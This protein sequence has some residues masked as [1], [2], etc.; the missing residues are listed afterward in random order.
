M[1]TSPAVP[2]ASA[3]TVPNSTATGSR[4]TP[5][6]HAVLALSGCGRVST[7]QLGKWAFSASAIDTWELPGFVPIVVQ[8]GIADNGRD[9]FVAGTRPADGSHCVLLHVDLTA[10]TR[11]A[12]LLSETRLGGQVIK[13]MLSLQC[14]RTIVAGLGHLQDGSVTSVPMQRAAAATN[15][16]SWLSRSLPIAGRPG[17]SGRPGSASTIGSW[18]AGNGCGV[19]SIGSG[20]RNILAAVEMNSAAVVSSIATAPNH[21]GT[22]RIWN[23]SALQAL[24]AASLEIR[25]KCAMSSATGAAHRAVEWTDLP[26][27]ADAITHLAA[28]HFDDIVIS[29][30]ADGGV[31]LISLCA[32]EGTIKAPARSGVGSS[33]LRLVHKS[34]ITA[35][36]LTHAQLQQSLDDALGVAAAAEREDNATSASARSMLAIRLERD[37]EGDRDRCRLLCAEAVEMRE[38]FAAHALRRHESAIAELADAEAVTKSRLA[39]AKERRENVSDEL[40][41]IRQFVATSTAA[42]AAATAANCLECQSKCK[43]AVAIEKEHCAALEVKQTSLSTLFASMIV[44]REAAADDALAAHSHAH[45]VALAVETASTLLLRGENGLMKRRFAAAMKELTDQRNELTSLRRAETELADGIVGLQR[46]II[47]HQ[48]EVHERDQVVAD[49]DSRIFELRRKNQ[50][51]INAGSE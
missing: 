27:H 32:P 50:V 47:A 19:R 18:G 12:A 17:S 13:S 8:C 7:G 1:M 30:S 20:R 2:T 45:D 33:E 34:A 11:D 22:L 9:A 28:T 39:V 4:N 24:T 15:G 14:G 23:E 51:H 43:I 38:R 29:G 31:A 6:T 40:E 3:H 5:H 46:D 48:K 42:A 26:V 44:T 35:L 16:G 21:V 25:S 49:K 10:T 41:S 36:R 37:A